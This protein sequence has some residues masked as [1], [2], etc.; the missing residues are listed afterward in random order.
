[1]DAYFNS[2]IMR[3]YYIFFRKKELPKSYKSEALISTGLTSRFEQTAL[4]GGQNMDYFK[5][6]QQ[7]GNLLEMMKSKRTINLLS[8]KLLLHDLKDS[9]NAFK[10][11]SKVIQKL[12][13]QE[14]QQAIIEFEKISLKQP[15]VDSR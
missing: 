2:I 3:G 7:F 4:A 1:M 15:A 13:E 5:L 9:T 12:S 11:Y 8:Y 10:P 6:S 14:R